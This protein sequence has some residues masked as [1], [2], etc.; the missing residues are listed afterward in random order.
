MALANL[1]SYDKRLGVPFI[2][3]MLALFALL[4]SLFG[5]QRTAG[6]ANERL[7]ELQQ[8]WQAVQDGTVEGSELVATDRM[9]QRVRVPVPVVQNSARWSLGLALLS[10]VF[11]AWLVVAARRAQ[12]DRMTIDDGK[13]RLEQAS[14]VK[15]LDEMAPLASGDLRVRATVTDA[16]TGALADAFNYAVSELRWLVGTMGHSAQQVDDSVKRTRSTAN[17]VVKACSE[18]TRQI[19]R[20]SNFLLTMSAA[21]AELSADASDSSAAA[22]AAADKAERGVIALDSSLERLSTIR[23]E[24]DSTTRLMHRLADNVRAI[25]EHV[26]VVQEVAKS[27]DLLALNTT[28]R[29]SAGSRSV[30]SSDAAADLGRLSDEVAQLADVLGQATRE[31]GSLTRTITQDAADTVQSM[32]H[33]TAELAAGVE[34]TEQ[35]SVALHAIH[36]DSEVVRQRVALMAEKTVQQSGIVRQLSDNMDAISQITQQTSDGVHNNAE[37]LDEL[38]E[39]AAELRQSLSDFKL[40]AKPSPSKSATKKP[41]MHARQRIGLSYMSESDEGASASGSAS[42]PDF[43]HEALAHLQIQG[44]TFASHV[45]AFLDASTDKHR[46][47]L[48]D[49]LQRFRNTLVLL[50]KGA[51]V[52]VAEELIHLLECD[53]NG[54]VSNQPELARVLVQAADQLSA[55]VAQLQQDGQLDS[56]LAMLTLVNDS[57]ACRDESLLSE[58]VVLAAGIKVPQSK[59]ASVTDERWQ[60]QRE[61]W[62]SFTS[63][64]HGGFAQK[65]LRWWRV[66]DSATAQAL[67]SHLNKFEQF[68]SERDYL[69]VLVPL[70]QSAAL[71]AEAVAARGLNDGPALR[72]L[73]AQLERNIHRSSLIAA[74]ED[75]LPADLLRNYLY[76][77]AQVESTSRVALDLRHRFRLD[78]IRQASRIDT[79]TA[80]PT[81][82]IGY[83]LANAIRQSVSDETEAL[84]HWLDQAPTRADHPKVVRLRVRL[85][86]L[87]PVLTLMGAPQA[88]ACLQGINVDLANLDRDALPDGEQRLAIAESLLKLDVLLDESA[89]NSV[90]RSVSKSDSADI[91][92][93]DVFIDMAT[94]ACLREARARL[95][96]LGQSLEEL[97]IAGPLPAGRCHHLSVQLGNIDNAL[98]VLPLPEVR[99]LLRGL[100][101]LLTQLQHSGRGLGDPTGTQA[102]DHQGQQ[103]AVQRE[104]ATLLVSLD[105]YLACVLSPQPAAGQL[106]QDAFDA[107]VRAR[108]QLG[109]PD[110]REMP[111]GKID[112]QEHS[113]VALLSNMDAIGNALAAYRCANTVQNQQS[114][115]AALLDF[116]DRSRNLSP[117]AISQLASATKSWFAHV[118]SEPES[119]LDD[120]QLALLDEV[121]A[122]IP[123]VID[124][125]MGGSDDIHRFDELLEQLAV[126]EH[127][128]AV[129]D[130]QALPLHD[131]GSLTL[132]VDDDLLDDPFDQSSH[133]GLDNTLQHVFYHECLSHLEALD[134]SVRLSLQPSTDLA[135]HL[136]TEQ[137]LR[138]LH[139]L[140]GSAQTVDAPEIVGIVQPL[141]R[142]ALARQ[143]LGQRFDAAETRYI[144]DLVMALRARLESLASGEPVGQSVRAVEQR[145]GSFVSASIPGSDAKDSGFGLASNVRSLDDVFGEEA[146]ELL[147]RLAAIVQTKD[148]A[149]TDSNDALALLHTLKGSARMA[150]RVAIADQAHA[151]EGM[152]QELDDTEEQRSALSSGY[153]QI[154]ALVM[155]ADAVLEEQP[156]PDKAAAQALPGALSSESLIVSDTAFDSLLD[157]ATDVTVN[158]AR[159]NDELVRLRE[160]YQEL[161]S[162]AQRWRELPASHALSDSVDLHEMLADLDTAR[163]VMRT[164][165]R[166]A[167]RE[168]QQASRASSGLQQ[169]L[170]RTRLVRIDELR[171][172]L[173]QIIDDAVIE[174]GCQAQLD[175]EGGEVTLDRVL[176]RQLTASLEHL[177]RNA[178]AHGI[179]P[180]D[181]RA[182]AGKP[183]IGRLVLSASVDGTDLVVSFSDDGRGIERESLSDLLQSRGEAG[184][185]SQE[186]LQSILFTSGFSSVEKPT[187]LAGHGLGLS[188]VQAAVEQM[189]GRVQLSTSPGNGTQITLRLPQRI[190]VNQVVLVSSEDV[191]FAIPVSYVDAVRVA[192]SAE[193]NSEKYRRIP[194][195]QMLLQRTVQSG[196]HAARSR[197]TV[198]ISAAGESLALEIDQVIGYR[199]L[200]TQ[201]LGPQLAALARF[202]GGSVLSDG[203]QVLI[204]DMHRIVESLNI[205]SATA[206]SSA[207]VSLRPVALIVDD[208]LT[209][210][211]AAQ[212]ILQQCGI[213]TRTSRDG[214]EALDSMA[215]ALPNLIVLDIEMP[216]L[217]GRDFLKRIKE[218]YGAACPPVIVVSSRDDL[219]N[220][221]RMMALGAVRFLAK[222]YTENQL[223]EAVEAAGLQ[224]PDLTIA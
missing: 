214:V 73:F 140:T 198:L 126:R 46:A 139:T 81:I 166:Q 209:M 196:N 87:E 54:G 123:Q 99:P 148:F 80:T 184:I 181:E 202:S 63:E 186:A 112:D 222:P 104:L 213:A 190:V 21:M 129:P 50:D 52:Y 170:I 70:F 32:E 128:A 10:L 33:T 7:N 120:Q 203:R 163:S 178:I 194:L 195:S 13:E 182:A 1:N 35:A 17:D 20:S 95:Q 11:L 150:G 197:P 146:G 192:N 143:R 189:G 133:Q 64:Q 167:E 82:G 149:Q 121:H 147:D 210:R 208:S 200:V 154:Q 12:R 38:Q 164:A 118:S 24:A 159:L 15:L 114:L 56:A 60:Q 22:K 53:A 218:Q 27:T 152:V 45:Q 14:I 41:A 224:L 43:S 91:R 107:L 6:I 119:R 40:P 79:G 77:V 187:A 153:S 165:L 100:M 37:S 26:L 141:Q 160:V 86:Q 205:D 76:Y 96:Q 211:V 206:A 67:S 16:M 59:P 177:A 78:R 125:A 74:P 62:L 138:A 66:E 162:T 127:S 172:R 5:L 30:S 145:L 97:L 84:R 110:W 179:E 42:I 55:H 151:I 191:L 2:L 137:M 161:E 44:D 85:K 130:S 220:K 176:F 101:D 98:Q 204:L 89:R 136:P 157:L 108:R 173:D 69:D 185:D 90:M 169:S 168:Q 174:V 155:Q 105:Y 122:V 51:A 109:N 158:Q 115:E 212:G 142:A 93:E 175:V 3:L 215:V 144:G 103:D 49:D 71:V 111:T 65:L 47:Q 83:Q 219:V 117:T 4:V 207:R 106:L 223:H 180:S 9:M 199:E 88:L 18:Q 36:D 94:D 25:D 217:D 132:N 124:Q 92:G 19:H 113:V 57:R 135:Q 201:A 156:A 31:I 34:Q 183:V 134:E 23:D 28:I 58:M 75:L 8:T 61:S 68:C 72:S 29:A 171:E 216:R 116:D 39:L 131:T 221:E 102:A 188:A 48:L 193:D